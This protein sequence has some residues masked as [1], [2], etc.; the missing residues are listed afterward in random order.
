MFRLV[1]LFPFSLKYKIGRIYLNS[2]C[3]YLEN[4]TFRKDTPEPP[5]MVASFELWRWCQRNYATPKPGTAPHTLL[6]STLNLIGEAGELMLTERQSALDEAKA[7]L[8]R[9]QNEYV[10]LNK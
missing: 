9:I 4:Y 6:E 2:E 1:G 7:E 8:E 10:E 5:A 3:R